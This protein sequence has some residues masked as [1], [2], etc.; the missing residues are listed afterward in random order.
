MCFARPEYLIFLWFIIPVIALSAFG[1]RRKLTARKRIEGAGAS[2]ILPPVDLSKFVLRRAML[3]AGIGLL[4]FAM[5]GPELCRGQKP[6][7]RK[8][9][10]V[11][12]MLD[13]SNSMLAADVLPDRLSRAKSEILQISRSLGESRKALML[14]AGAPVVQS[15][16]TSDQE[17]FEMLLDM[18]SPDLIG[19]QGTDYRRAFDMALRLGGSSGSSSGSEMVLVLASD[20]EDHG[21]DFGDMARTLKSLGVHFHAIGVGTGEPVP[22]PMPG[23]PKRDRQGQVVM[24]RFRPDVFGAIVRESGGNFYHSRPDAPVHDFVSSDI[25]A[26]AASA[27]WIM[28]PGQRRPVH[29]ECIIAAIL[30]CVAGAAISDVRSSGTM[31]RKE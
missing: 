5:A 19:P 22:V 13:V 29:R 16:L 14:F 26:E 28:V 24:T 10:D 4:L 7:R 8:G 21:P 1:A 18:A 15:P 3:C 2:S 11:V 31:A 17:G 9:V 27:R 6:L 25:A 23:G 12:F 30:L 20:G